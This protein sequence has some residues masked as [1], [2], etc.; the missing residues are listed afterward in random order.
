MSGARCPCIVYTWEVID[1]CMCVV[2]CEI[3]DCWI[4]KSFVGMLRVEYETLAEIFMPW[5]SPGD[6]PTPKSIATQTNYK[7]HSTCT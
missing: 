1:F 4:Q 5:F 2:A 7:I 3:C 6:T